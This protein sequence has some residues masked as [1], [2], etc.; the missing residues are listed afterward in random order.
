MSEVYRKTLKGQHLRTNGLCGNSV[1]FV[2]G[3]SSFLWDGTDSNYALGNDERVMEDGPENNCGDLIL[4][5]IPLLEY[6][7]S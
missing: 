4:R 7:G 3:Q 5:K 1:A 2:V 6:G